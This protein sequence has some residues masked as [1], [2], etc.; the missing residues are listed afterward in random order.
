MAKN[1]PDDLIDDND[2]WDF[3]E[4]IG[5]VPDFM[6][7]ED[8]GDSDGGDRDPKSKFKSSIKK[9]VSHVG[10]EASKGAALGIAHGIENAMPEVR[11]AY[12]TATDAIS[13]LNRLKYDVLDKSRPIINETKKVTKQLLRQ[14]KGMVPFGLDQKLLAFLD[15]HAPD[16]A[17]REEISK[18][19][20]RD[21]NLASMLEGVFQLQTEKAIETQQNEAVNRVM[22]EKLTQ[23]RH[24]ESMS[25]MSSMKNAIFYQTAFTKSVFTSYLK[26]DLELKLRH[27]YVAQDTLGVLTN[28]SK[29]LEQRLDAITKNTSLPDAVKVTTTET[30]RRMLKE[31]FLTSMGGKVDKV[32]STMRENIMDQYVEPFLGGMEMFNTTT[33]MVGEFLQQQNEMMEQ[34]YSDDVA[35]NSKTGLAGMGSGWLGGIFGGKIARK[36]LN[37]IP[38][39]VRKMIATDLKQGKKGILKALHD[40][41]DNSDGSLGQFLSDIIPEINDEQNIKNFTYEN[42]DDAG[43]V[44]NKTVETIEKII[45]GYLAMQTHFLEMMATSRDNGVMAWDFKNQKFAYEK[46]L[47]N[48]VKEQAFGDKD[49]RANIINAS[50]ERTRSIISNTYEGGI[51]QAKTLTLQ[52]D[53]I[54][55]DVEKFKLGLASSGVFIT[56]NE[57]DI[58]EIK[59]VADGG[60]LTDSSDLWKY[61]FSRC[62]SPATVATF[63]LALF[64]DGRNKLAIKQFTSDIIATASNINSRFRNVFAK[65]GVD[66]DQSF[67]LN[68]FGKRQADGSLE[69]DNASFAKSL[70]DKIEESDIRKSVDREK[71]DQFGNAIIDDRKTG[72][73]VL[74]WV[75]KKFKSGDLINNITSKIKDTAD[76]TGSSV[77]EFLYKHLGSTEKAGAKQWD[78]I[79]K[80]L[81]DGEKYAK[82][83][84]NEVWGTATDLLSKGGDEAS[85]LVYKFVEN[86]HDLKPLVKLLFVTKGSKDKKGTLKEVI[87]N[88]DYAEFCQDSDK[89]KS[90][91]KW[92]RDN[93]RSNILIA[94]LVDSS[95]TLQTLLLM[96][97]ETVHIDPETGKEVVS[98]PFDEVAKAKKADQAN[99]FNKVYDEVWKKEKEIEKNGHV[100][101][102][103]RMTKSYK[104]QSAIKTNTANTKSP[105]DFGKSIAAQQLDV[106]RQNEEHLSFMRS[107]LLDLASTSWAGF[108]EKHPNPPDIESIR[109]SYTRQNEVHR[110]FDAITNGNR[111]HNTQELDPDN[112]QYNIF[113]DLEAKIKANKNRSKRDTFFDTNNGDSEFKRAWKL[114]NFYKGADSEQLNNLLEQRKHI[115]SDT[116]VETG[117][118]RYQAELDKIDKKRLTEEKNFERKIKFLSDK[119]SSVYQRKLREYIDRGY[120][121]EQAEKQIEQE[122]N[123][124]KGKFKQSEEDYKKEFKEVSDELDKYRKDT[125]KNGAKI[126]K[127]LSGTGALEDKFYARDKNGNIIFDK[128]RDENGNIILG[129]VT[130]RLT[131][132]G[133]FE[134]AWR[135]KNKDAEYTRETVDGKIVNLTMQEGIQRNRSEL[136]SRIDALVKLGRLTTRTAN[137]W[138]RWKEARNADIA[139]L[140]TQIDRQKYLRDEKIP[141][142]LLKSITNEINKIKDSKSAKGEELSTAEKRTAESLENL[143][144]RK[145]ALEAH[146]KEKEDYYA[147]K[148]KDD[149]KAA[150]EKEQKEKADEK[151]RKSVFDL[152]DK[153]WNKKHSKLS[154]EERDNYYKDFELLSKSRAT[155]NIALSILEK[156]HWIDSTKEERQGWF[157]HISNLRKQEEERKQEEAEAAKD[158]DL[159]KFLQD[160]GIKPKNVTQA[161]LDEGA[162][163]TEAEIKE[164]GKSLERLAKRN[165]KKADDRQH[166]QNKKLLEAEGDNFLKDGTTLEEHGGVTDGWTSILDGKGIA[167]EAGKETILPHKANE[168]FKKL[169]FNAVAMTFGRETAIKV[170]NG[171]DPNKTTLKE[172]GIGTLKFA[173]GATIETETTP[174]DSNVKDVTVNSPLR[175]IAFAQL[176][177]LRDIR[178]NGGGLNFNLDVLAK[179]K[180]GGDWFKK[181]YKSLKDKYSFGGKLKR[182]GKGT[183]DFLLSPFGMIAGA[184]TNKQIDVFRLPKNEDDPLDEPLITEQDF[185]DGLYADPDLKQRIKSVDDIK[186]NVWNYKGELVLTENDVK[187]GL[188]DEDRKPIS[189]WARKFGR[190]IRKGV[191]F[192]AKLAKFPFTASWQTVT[193]FLFNDTCDIYL[194]PGDDKLPLGQ[195]LVT[196]SDFAAGLYS[197]EELKDRITSAADIKGDV[198]DRTGQLRIRAEEVPFLCDEK[199]R[200]IKTAFGRLGRILRHGLGGVYNA[201]KKLKPLKFA[202]KVITA[203]FRFA[204][205]VNKRNVDVYSKRDPSKLLVSAKDILAGKLMFEDGETVEAASDIDKPVWWKDIPQNGDKAGTYAVEPEDLQAGLIELDGTEIKGRLGIAGDI[206][207]HIFKSGIHLAGKVIGGVLKFG[208]AVI[209]TTFIGKNSFIDVYVKDTSGDKGLVRRLEGVK[210]K[211]GA[212]YKLKNDE[213]VPLKSAY[214]I[215]GEVYTTVDG[216]PQCLISEDELKDGVYDAEGNKLRRFGDK[217]LVGLAGTALAYGA[218]KVIGG[219]GKG[220]K[221]IGNFIGGLFNR[222]K[223]IF[224]SIG[225]WFKNLDFAGTGLFL[226]RRDLEE[227]V[228]D[229][230]LDIYHLL[231]VRLPDVKKV[232]GDIDGDGDRENSYE[233]YMQR[234]AERKKAKEEKQKKE[235]EKKE[236]KKKKEE[237]KKQKASSTENSNSEEGVFKSILSSGG[238]LISDFLML[239]WLKGGKAVPKVPGAPG[240]LA[241]LASKLG[242]GIVGSKFGKWSQDRLLNNR[243]TGEI[244]TN[245]NGKMAGVKALAKGGLDATKRG[246]ASVAGKV[247][248]RTAAGVA[249]SAAGRAAVGT[250]ARVG[251]GTAARIG[252]GALASLAVGGAAN[253]WNPV[254]WAMLAATLGC[255]GYEAYNLLKTDPMDLRWQRLRFP[256]YGLDESGIAYEFKYEDYIKDLE[257]DTFNAIINGE[258]ID[259]SKLEHFGINVGFLAGGVLGSGLRIG[260]FKEDKELKSKRMEY[261]KLWYCKRFFPAFDSY[262]SLIKSNEPADVDPTDFPDVTMI[263]Y[264][265]QETLLD[266][267]KQV[268]D[269]I[270]SNPEFYDE[271]IDI[272][273]EKKFK[274]WVEKEKE[275]EKERKANMS[276]GNHALEEALANGVEDEYFSYSDTADNFSQAWYNLKKGNL[277]DATGEAVMG[278]GS[279]VTETIAGVFK[280]AGSFFGDST[281]ETSWGKAKNI[282]YGLDEHVD[283]DDLEDFEE[284][285]AEILHHKRGEF[286]RVELYDEI[287]DLLDET[288]FDADDFVDTA[289]DVLGI[290]ETAAR[291]KVDDYFYSW[292]TK[293]F[294]IILKVFLAVAAGFAGKPVSSFDVDDIPEQYRASVLKKFSEDAER[295]LKEFGSDK[296]ELTLTGYHAF[297]R[298][299]ET[300]ESA[301]ALR[302]G[303]TTTEKIFGAIYG[304]QSRIDNVRDKAI[305]NFDATLAKTGYN[306]A[307]AGIVTA[308]TAVWDFFFGDSVEVT[309]WKVRYK[310]Y[311]LSKELYDPLWLEN[312]EDSL[313]HAT[314]CFNDLEKY[315]QDIIDGKEAFAKD[316]KIE[317]RI[318]EIINRLGF[319]VDLSLIRSLAPYAKSDSKSL[320]LKSIQQPTAEE[321]RYNSLKRDY[322]ITW[323]KGSFLPIFAIYAKIVRDAC[324]AEKGDDINVDDIPEDI[325][326]ETLDNFIKNAE[327]F[328]ADKQDDIIQLSETEFEKYYKS[329]ISDGSTNSTI[330][331]SVRR[332]FE[333]AAIDREEEAYN[334]KLIT[335][336]A[337]NNTSLD[338]DLSSIDSDVSNDR[339]SL[340]S[341]DYTNPFKYNELKV[342]LAGK[343]FVYNK[344]LSQ[345]ENWRYQ[346]CTAYGDSSII[347]R[348][349]YNVEKRRK[350]YRWLEKGQFDHFYHNEKYD[351]KT[352]KERLRYIAEA[353]GLITDNDKRA[354]I[355]EKLEY[356]YEWYQKRFLPIFYLFTII[357]KKLGSDDGINLKTIET[358]FVDDWPLE[359]YMDNCSDS[360][361]LAKMETFLNE[362]NKLKS[363]YPD[364]L[365]PISSGY[366]R[367]LKEKHKPVEIK[368]EEK[369][370]EIKKEPNRPKISDEELKKISGYNDYRIT[371]NITLPD[372]SN[373]TQTLPKKKFA[374]G[375]TIF[376]DSLH[377]D[378]GVVDEPTEIANNALAGEAGTETILPHKGGQRF[379]DLVINAI[380]EVYGPKF[381]DSV[382]EVL[383][384]N[385]TR[386][387]FKKLA[388]TDDELNE[389]LSSTTD[390]LLFN[391][392]KRISLLTNPMFG[393]SGAMLSNMRI[394][395]KPGGLLETISN[396]WNSVKTTARD[397]YNGAVNGVSRGMT[398]ARDLYGNARDIYGNIVNGVSR[399]M[400]TARDWYNGAVNGV[401]RGMTYARDLYGNARDMV[402]GTWDTMKNIG[403]A[404]GSSAKDFYNNAVNIGSTVGSSVKDMVS[405]TWDTV[406]NFGSSVAIPRVMNT[407]D[408]QLRVAKKIWKQFKSEG[409]SDQ[410]IAGLLGNIQKESGMESVRM[411]GDLKDS[412]RTKSIE[413]TKR[414][415]ANREAFTH[416]NSIG[417]GLCQWT[418]SKRK[419]NLWD[420]CHKRNKSVGDEDSQIEFISYEINKLGGL[421]SK[422][423]STLK[424]C[425]NITQTTEILL[426]KYE[427]PAKKDDPAEL[428]ERCKYALE[429]WKKLTGQED[430]TSSTEVS[431]MD[432][433][434]KSAKNIYDTASNIGKAVGSSAKDLY[435]TTVNVGKAVGSSVK[436]MYNTTV[437]IGKAVGSSMSDLSNDLSKGDFGNILSRTAQG[438]SDLANDISAAIGSDSSMDNGN[439]ETNREG[440]NIEKY[441]N[442]KQGVDLKNEHPVLKDR[443]AAMAKEFAELFGHKPVIN[444]GK[445]SLK[446]Q[447]VLFKKY[448]P[449]RAARPNPLAP[450]I[451]GLALDADSGDMNAA[452]SAGLLQKYGLWRPLKNWAKTKE[453]WHVEVVGSRPE[454]PG[455]QPITKQTLSAIDNLSKSGKTSADKAEEGSGGVMGPNNEMQIP[456]AENNK[457][458]SGGVGNANNDVGV[459]NSAAGNVL[460]DDKPQI[461]TDTTP[462]K[463]VSTENHTIETDSL[464]NGSVCTDTSSV[465]NQQLA[466]LQ[467]ISGL[468]KEIKDNT[469]P[470]GDKTKPEENE[471]TLKS[472]ETKPSKDDTTSVLSALIPILQTIADKLSGGA[473]SDMKSM[474]SNSGVKSMDRTFSSPL[475][476]AKA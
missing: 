249:A 99:V 163:F 206:S 70:F 315:A 370:Q 263:P 447:E 443:F 101:K 75:V 408:D 246:A 198:W 431:F 208:K 390:L 332:K 407:T 239:K 108:A 150:K 46:D 312:D 260:V 429:W 301:S 288:D 294:Q 123:D 368:R 261:L 186:G 168:R 114:H 57:S 58:E 361:F 34:G 268:L 438:A 333:K 266:Q 349:G 143:A 167:G 85:K 298:N 42:P 125:A 4:D 417:Y 364:W 20:E 303:E 49:S 405:G 257:K 235:E 396:G 436:D 3:D 51:K 458:V 200:P 267:Y 119:D 193:N 104:N 389:H 199:R 397:W 231:Y 346:L 369:A 402:S 117:A 411:Q 89:A 292:Y 330:D 461:T 8:D 152:L 171:L 161:M 270:K 197:D 16:E 151:H 141:E 410:A 191:K 406:K 456:P 265:I 194:N 213:P 348:Q 350:Y 295:K 129:E 153:Q 43:K 416:P 196:S 133:I 454:G 377:R 32:F 41:A 432:E 174:T 35:W 106:L 39:K 329:V 192:A 247:F 313:A 280:Y 463:N 73:K 385:K 322:A 469:S 430:K 102:L 283:F 26:K 180:N 82:D 323:F 372:D 457:T 18:E 256:M 160:K 325:A 122:L 37:K 386:R 149:E 328:N 340:Y 359:N 88:Q 274:A 100:A 214:D 300:T 74:D 470:V 78:K 111:G 347:P 87:T 421:S 420:F 317:C 409:W 293:R 321:R 195:P 116:D 130:P 225:N 371:D 381:A 218:K 139:K 226:N 60:H 201:V 437:N 181:K 378:G 79:T 48:D 383:S 251:A 1:S 137:S 302:R 59:Q 320:L 464:A 142:G 27:F 2:N 327:H 126:K 66:L 71:F 69:L 55:M 131:K 33:E 31:K 331:D 187:A 84:I 354:I 159:S 103:Q 21:N 306:F 154:D 451:S 264:E 388:I 365:T 5:G 97:E 112:E 136:I 14:T 345:Q 278:V 289:M 132:E 238:D 203:P 215:D 10:K 400:T 40:I 242:N 24:T 424:R 234:Q 427:A 271:S 387:S 7:E 189:S 223:D 120:T 253:I 444:G 401:S 113:A 222:G 446:Q 216:M 363:N 207:K 177:V 229:R 80:A 393:S 341:I 255:L 399:G 398:Y 262:C 394:S 440:N 241:T 353:N 380:K 92:I 304:V 93:R 9:S 243:I 128:V 316:T 158:S 15:K 441:V 475:N 248:G 367:W 471:I 259:I 204:S 284:I 148:E 227:V 425:D 50:I 307:L 183:I 23:S 165:A 144:K 296:Y 52:Y 228:G 67:I 29:M 415:D 258:T 299:G 374:R 115:T 269:K 310:Y 17:E 202:W 426:K 135:E 212:Y 110:V 134:T 185:K 166:K 105:E 209:D 419:E 164:W 188:C 138:R 63:L 395:L 373:L 434:G 162:T 281:Y 291:S 252:V 184:V 460:K 210:I 56:F 309:N 339:K 155:K 77:F 22:D 224:S 140:T 308:G 290:S 217:S 28:T 175:Q 392:Y 449:G 211:D 54:A 98:T 83:K 156:E 233:D 335:A 219:I 272:T 375:G 465:S 86:V 439:V 45:P 109:E 38:S 403:N 25:V 282:L 273:D 442:K 65:Y 404:V 435:D 94:S 473:P 124:I 244:L 433:L 338:K 19:E 391:L 172:L 472:Q 250:A 279:L 47:I 11:D 44:T 358:S 254:G 287:D 30:A 275:A 466:E 286:T 324:K 342:K 157:S 81:S 476:I 351:I 314:D 356:M 76:K 277:L 414:A 245:P 62:K 413:Y 178:E 459:V 170:L 337:R 448:G 91:L 452:E 326:R 297:L 12:N 232:D 318:L 173:D 96:F 450:H 428:V 422:L 453:P 423:L 237:E 61:G 474:T 68:S 355:D 305:K 176:E 467:I 445:R 285:A 72:E 147:Q 412:K 53:A 121:K 169:I 376:V 384:G 146:N 319:Y 468:L 334:K 205:L 107:Y 382:D 366:V 230:L 64:K 190:F 220:I 276:V 379:N 179:L 221:G 90:A 118:L 336:I 127:Q 418:Y 13:E 236:K 343:G 357:V 95:Q 360:E 344:N 311:N 462:T 36:L 240:R 352:I 6:S 455:I 182:F 145:S 362:V